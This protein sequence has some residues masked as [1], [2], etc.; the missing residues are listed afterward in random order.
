MKFRIFVY[1]LLWPMRRV[2][3]LKRLFVAVYFILC[4]FSRY[5]STMFNVSEDYFLMTKSQL[6]DRQICL[7]RRLDDLKLQKIDIN[8]EIMNCE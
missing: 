5:P 6:Y 4:G 7:S 8:F 3:G 2:E 1:F